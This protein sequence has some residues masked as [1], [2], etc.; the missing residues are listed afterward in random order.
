MKILIAA[1]I[2]SGT[3]YIYRALN[4]VG[5][6]I[7][8]EK[9]KKDGLVGYS[10][11]MQDLDKYEIIV[12]QT[13]ETLK[14]ISSASTYRSFWFEICEPHLNITSDYPKICH[15]CNKLG[16]KKTDGCSMRPKENYVCHIKVLRTM[17]YWHAMCQKAEEISSWRYKIEDYYDKQ[18]VRL[19]LHNLVGAKTTNIAFENKSSSSGYTL[20]DWD[21]LK[22]I[23][24]ELT[25]MIKEKTEMYGY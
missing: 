20:L 8:H 21:Y 11:I 23:D 1:P 14:S 16:I 17:R 6:E 7:G 12:Q 24:P 18:S 3:K 22:K 10:F 13:R 25:K 5:I 4:D 15:E 19:H 9:P 2:K